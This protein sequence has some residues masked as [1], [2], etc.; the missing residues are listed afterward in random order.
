MIGI[1]ALAAAPSYGSP[2]GEAAI[3]NGDARPMMRS[4]VVDFSEGGHAACGPGTIT[5]N[6]EHGNDI[7]CADLWPYLASQGVNPAGASP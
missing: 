7:G 5:L 6:D 2:G 4:H 1:S 3:E